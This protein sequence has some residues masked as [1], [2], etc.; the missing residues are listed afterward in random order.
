[1][2]NKKDEPLE[3]WSRKKRERTLKEQSRAKNGTYLPVLYSTLSI[4]SKTY[5]RNMFLRGGNDDKH[6]KTKLKSK[7]GA[8]GK[9][10]YY[11]SD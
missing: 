10:F 5:D 1:M 7:W 9:C 11:V 8:Q 3:I 4:H 6:T 2:E